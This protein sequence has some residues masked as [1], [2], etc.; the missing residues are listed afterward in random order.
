MNIKQVAYNVKNLGTKIGAKAA[1]MA[2]SKETVTK[3][4][5]QSK[6]KIANALDGLASMGKAAVSNS[7]KINSQKYISPHSL[8]QMVKKQAHREN[9][10]IQESLANGMS[11][12]TAKKAA[13][14]L[15]G[16]TG[17]FSHR[18]AE[19]SAKVFESAGKTF[20]ER[21]KAMLEKKAD[22]LQKFKK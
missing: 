16:A 9:A 21:T 3:A 22:L 2:P 14:A 18:S 10:L 1:S 4:V 12:K 7:N 5:N 15:I 20:A 6:D 8:S 17:K 11:K 13:D 19:E